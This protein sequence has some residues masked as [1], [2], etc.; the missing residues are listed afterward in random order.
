[1]WHLKYE[2]GRHLKFESWEGCQPVFAR[3]FLLIVECYEQ[4]IKMVVSE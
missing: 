4:N 2:D 3:D 1:M